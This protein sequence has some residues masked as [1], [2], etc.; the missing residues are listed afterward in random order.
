MNVTVII[1]DCNSVSITTSTIEDFEYRIGDGI[2][3]K[4]LDPFYIDN[5][6]GLCG[7]FLYQLEP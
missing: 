7:D 4:I 3:T 1:I 6:G 5:D 2:K